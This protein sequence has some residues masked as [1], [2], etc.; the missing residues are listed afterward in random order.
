MA[1]NAAAP[2]VL[3][4]N[5]QTRGTVLCARATVA[6]GFH[7]R[8][9]GL[10]RHRAL[11]LDEGMLFEAEP[12]IPLMWMHTFFM[13]FPIDIVFF[14][15]TDVV[16]KVQTS[17]K[18]WRLSAIMFGARKAVELSAGAANRSRTVVGDVIALE[19]V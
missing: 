5:N 16:M 10:M 12:L 2:L 11:G 19:K 8:T 3:R 15:R 13:T 9:R 17:L 6:Q 14:D 7:G 18:P 4:V 1:S